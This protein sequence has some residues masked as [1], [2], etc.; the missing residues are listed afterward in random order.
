MRSIFTLKSI[1]IVVGTILIAVLVYIAT[2]GVWINRNLVDT[3]S[4]VGSTVATF[5]DET[6][7]DALADLVVVRIVEDRPLLTLV[8]PLLSDLVAGLLDGDRLEAML[9]TIGIKL[10][11]ILFDGTQTGIVIDL[12]PVGDLLMPPL[13]RLFPSIADEIPAD[14]FREIV[15]VEPGTVPELSPYAKGVRALT[16]IAIIL[17]IALIVIHLVMRR[18]K[19]KAVLS[20]GIAF[21]GSGL[22]TVVL[23]NQAR[24]LTVASPDNADVATLVTNL[25]DNLTHSLRSYGW[26]VVVLGLVITAGSVVMKMNLPDVPEEG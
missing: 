20:V 26:W 6:S 3:E 11:G 13:E 15:L 25:F 9:T 10:H 19:W 16:W 17:V 24:R 23:V 21:V 4:F 7:R 1:P 2:F 8:S 22:A 12:T 14:V 18:S 5:E